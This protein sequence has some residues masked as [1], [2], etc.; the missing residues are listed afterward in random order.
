M[1]YYIHGY[2]SS[3]QSTKGTLFEKTL[4]A[5]AIQYRECK[6]EDI[7]IAECLDGIKKALGNDT[8]ITLIGSSL[9]GFLAAKTAHENPHVRHLI[10]LNPAIIPPSVD[11]TAIQ[12]MPKTILRE[13]KDYRLFEE[14]IDADIL[15]LI[16][17][18]DEVVPSHWVLEF[19]MAQEAT[20]KFLQDDHSFTN[21]LDRLPPMIRAYLERQKP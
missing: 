20:V 1:L 7:I 18:E 8:D 5:K 11:I 17:T 4:Q 9:G 6:P 15:I 14:K 16:G 12:G 13:M 3:P 2:E 19:A 21:Q 10:L